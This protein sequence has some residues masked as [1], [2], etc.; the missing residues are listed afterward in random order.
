[1]GISMKDIK[2]LRSRTGAGVLDCKKAL[3]ETNGDIDAAVEYLREKGIAAAAKK[4][5]RVAA[6]G[7]VNV[8]ISDD[9]K[10]GVIVEVN[11]E[12]DF[13]AK[14]DNFKDLVN[15]IS[16]HLMQSDANSVDEVLKETWYQDSEKDVNTIIKEAIASIGENI[17]LRRFEKYETNGFLQG[18]IHMGGKIGVLVDID[19]EFNDSTR[20]V[21]KDI[22]MHI[23]AINPRYLS[24]D[25]ISEEVINKEKEIYKE[26][27]LNEGKPEHII[28]Q[29][30]KGKMEKYYSEVCLLDQAFVRDED[31]TV[32]KLIED[33][34]LKIN[35]FT[36]F[37]LGEGIEK[38][39]EDFA[40]EVMK[41]VNKK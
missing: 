38:E 30:V 19:G 8:Y 26:Q 40:A 34:G 31:I 36:R 11:S 15:K 1:M 21:A 35:G 10:K 14:N 22:A 28:G 33:N 24:R 20:K 3:A 4:A 13:V 37:E 32:G 41:E 5:G 39:E 29:I 7:A 16:E 23:A 17:N 12:T 9:R 2:E 25:D 6:E 27:M 18:Y